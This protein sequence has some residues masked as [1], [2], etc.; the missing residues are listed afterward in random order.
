MDRGR[1]AHVVG[2]LKYSKIDFKA[3]MEQI[4]LNDEKAKI[5]ASTVGANMAAAALN[6][7]AIPYEGEGYERVM[8]HHYQALNY[9]K[10]NDL[11]GAGVE[12]RRAN[13]EQM[14]ALKRFE[15]DIEKAQKEAE[16]KKVETNSLSTVT[17]KYA[18]MDEVAGKVKNSF[19]NAYTFYLSGLVY[20][21]NKEPNDAYIDYKK[22]LE[23]YPENSYLQKDVIRLAASL[24]IQDDVDALK[25]R[26]KIITPEV[27]NTADGNDGELL[28]I[29]EEGF[30]PQK[31]EIKIPIPIPNV[32]LL[33]IAFPIYQEK[34][35]LQNNLVVSENTVQIGLTETICDFRALAVKSLQEKVPEIATR[36]IV[37]AVVKGAASYA[38]KQK[39]GIAGELAMGVYNY[40][41]ES[42]DLRSWITL[43]ANAQILRTQMKTGTHKLALA[44]AGVSSPI[45]VDVV[46]PPSGK[47]IL[48]VVRGGN[49]FYMSTTPFKQRTIAAQL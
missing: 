8:L 30:V 32:G 27:L 2:E 49:Q 15:S 39:L 43:P 6:D 7:N 41:S 36:Q 25:E 46:I 42:A 5:S 9:V 24:G 16:D 20:E 3:S 19:Q 45:F 35:T 17:S 34:W 12:I 23:I 38:A 21:L 1:V 29:Y 48:H 40:V 33:A 4:Q 10:Q 28:V 26:F 18:Q 14:D 47:T 22:A 31:K 11:E 13:V 44:S 37:R